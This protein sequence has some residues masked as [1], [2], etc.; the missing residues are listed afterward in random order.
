[1]PPGP[2]ANRNGCERGEEILASPAPCERAGIVRG[3]VLAGKAR[4]VYSNLALDHLETFGRDGRRVYVLDRVDKAIV[5]NITHAAEY[6]SSFEPE[7]RRLL[8]CRSFCRG[9][10]QASRPNPRFR[11]QSP[12]VSTLSTGDDSGL[13]GAL[14]S[15]VGEP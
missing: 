1:M 3:L 9:T 5:Y 4:S 13:D 10:E 8:I 2:M 11:R 15:R 12:A 6:L 14:G 7:E